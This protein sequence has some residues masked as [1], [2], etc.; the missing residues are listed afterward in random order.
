MIW[1]FKQLVSDLNWLLS[2]SFFEIITMKESIKTDNKNFLF[3]LSYFN[4]EN[5]L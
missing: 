1:Y 5:I 4:T 3:S 2:G